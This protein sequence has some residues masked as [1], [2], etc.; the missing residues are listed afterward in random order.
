L[1]EV[2]GFIVVTKQNY[3]KPIRKKQ[4]NQKQQ[5]CSS[6]QEIYCAQDQ[7]GTDH[8]NQQMKGNSQKEIRLGGTSRF[9]LDSREVNGDKETEASEY[10]SE[11]NPPKSLAMRAQTGDGFTDKCIG[12]RAEDKIQLRDI[13]DGKVNKNILVRSN[14][15]YNSDFGRQNIE[16]QRSEVP[17]DKSQAVQTLPHGNTVGDRR[18]DESNHKQDM[19]MHTIAEG[20]VEEFSPSMHKLPASSARG[21]IYAN[22]YITQPYVH[23]L[24]STSDVKKLDKIENMATKTK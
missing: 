3:F 22:D 13:C 21:K 7:K 10:E 18:R 14:E 5:Q 6:E 12:T 15:I 16:C 20:C 23:A 2:S 8:Y 19:K 17:L 9:Y 4:Q 11:Q 24:D 1:E